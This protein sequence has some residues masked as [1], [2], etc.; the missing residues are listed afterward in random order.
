[1]KYFKAYVLDKLSLQK[2]F[3][4]WMSTRTCLSHVPFPTPNWSVP[5]SNK[6]SQCCV[7]QKV[8]PVGG[9][10]KRA[11]AWRVHPLSQ[12][13]WKNIS[14]I[15]IL[16]AKNSLSQETIYLVTLD[17][18][19]IRITIAKTC[20]VFHFIRLAF[21]LGATASTA[22]TSFCWCTIWNKTLEG[23][24]FGE[25]DESQERFTKNFLSKI[26]SSKKIH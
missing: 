11:T 9:N 20:S 10:C 1:M 3:A 25:F 12:H 21:S 26:F 13:Q 24:N 18:T 17:V 8:F 2:D 16:K 4:C 15:A 5:V 22:T 6:S 7:I 14:S 19:Y 23:E